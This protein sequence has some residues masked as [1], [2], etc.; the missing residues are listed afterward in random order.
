[1][2]TSKRN[3]YQSVSTSNRQA[4]K[5]AVPNLRWVRAIIGAFPL[6]YE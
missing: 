3:F 4:L 6:L 5:P 1:M 2:D